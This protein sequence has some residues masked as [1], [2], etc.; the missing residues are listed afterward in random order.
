MSDNFKRN[1]APTL[2]VGQLVDDLLLFGRDCEI[3]FGSTMAGAELVFYRTKRRGEN[4]VQIELNED[5]PEP[6]T[7]SVTIPKE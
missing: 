3:T 7:Y 5:F 4:L 6:G 2:T 1:Y